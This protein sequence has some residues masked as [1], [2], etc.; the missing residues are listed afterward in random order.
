[1]GKGKPAENREL[2]AAQPN[3]VKVARI[4]VA[5]NAGALKELIG[6]KIDPLRACDFHIAFQQLQQILTHVATLINPLPEDE[7]SEIS[8]GTVTLPFRPFALEGLFVGEN[9]ISLDTIAL[10]D[11]WLIATRAKPRPIAIE[12]AQAVPERAA[13]DQAN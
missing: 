8:E 11:G 7:R 13:A 6:L 5:N 2:P 1:M 12:K 9:G 4:I 3:K 10:L